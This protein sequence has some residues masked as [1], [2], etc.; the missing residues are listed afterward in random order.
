MIFKGTPRIHSGE[1]ERRIEERGAVTNAATSQD[2]THYH[3]TTAPKDFALLAPLQIDV[4]LNASIPDDPFE[5]E[6]LVVLEEIKRSEDNAQRRIYRR[7]MEL[8]YDSL[9]Y[10][11]PVLAQ[12]R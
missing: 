12:K 11:R 8:A 2:Y 1:F 7:A 10:R 5:R 9:P 4:V 3:I 6:R